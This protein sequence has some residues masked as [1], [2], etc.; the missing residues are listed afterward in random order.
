MNERSRSAFRQS[1][2]HLG[3][4][5]RSAAAGVCDLLTGVYHACRGTGVAISEKLAERRRRSVRRA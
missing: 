1:G 5:I 3:R 2:D 4:G